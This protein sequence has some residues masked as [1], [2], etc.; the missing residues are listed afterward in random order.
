[1]FNGFA[2]A[3]SGTWTPT[4]TFSVP[5]DLTVT[6]TSPLG[7]YFRQGNQVTLYFRVQTSSFTFTTA[8]GNLLLSGIPFPGINIPNLIAYGNC[9]WSG[10]TKANYTQIS[11][12]VT[13]NGSNLTFIA[14]GSGQTAVVLTA[15]DTPTGGTFFVGG[16]ITYTI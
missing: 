3:P 5:G 11:I 12:R 16:S 9:Q 10:I 15:A 1:M 7:Y 4:L 13:P 8:S 14:M 2:S 6:Y